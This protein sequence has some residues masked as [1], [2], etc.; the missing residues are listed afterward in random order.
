MMMTTGTVSTGTLQLMQVLASKRLTSL[1]GMIHIIIIMILMIRIIY[2]KFI[3]MINN[4]IMI[5]IDK[6]I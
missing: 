3:I 2:M 4:V 6:M 1:P 5:M